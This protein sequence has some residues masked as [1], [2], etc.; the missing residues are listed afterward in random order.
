[1]EF[2]ELFLSYCKE[3]DRVWARMRIVDQILSKGITIS[4]L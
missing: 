3:M 1:M 2:T 4:Y